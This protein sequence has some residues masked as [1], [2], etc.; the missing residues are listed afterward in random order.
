MKIVQKGRG[1]S[2]KK[3]NFECMNKNDIL[4]GGVGSKNLCHFFK[5][6]DIIREAIKKNCVFCDIDIKGGW[7]PVAKPNFFYRRNCD[8]YQRWVGV[9]HRCHNF[10]YP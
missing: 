9:K 4:L 8:I 3:S 1:V 6:F 5:M 7:V 10:I 2:E